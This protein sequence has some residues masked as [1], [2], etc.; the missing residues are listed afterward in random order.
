MS[1][2]HCGSTATYLKMGFRELKICKK[3]PVFMEV[4]KWHEK[5]CNRKI[6]RSFSVHVQKCFC[7]L[8]HVIFAWTDNNDNVFSI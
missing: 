2:A 7:I 5:V 4:K 8:L 6:V 3:L 1:V